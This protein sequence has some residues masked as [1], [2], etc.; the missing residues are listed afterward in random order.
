MRTALGAGPKHLMRQHGVEGLLYGLPEGVAGVAV[1]TA[2]IPAHALI[3]VDLPAWMQ[4]RLDHRNIAFAASAS[5]G[6]GLVISTASLASQM[7]PNLAK[8]LRQGDKGG[9]ET[10]LSSRSH[11]Q[12]IA[13][14]V[15]LSASLWGSR[16][17]STVKSAGG[18]ARAA[19][20]AVPRDTQWGLGG[21]L[22]RTAAHRGPRGSRPPRRNPP[23]APD[24]QGALPA[25]EYRRGVF[26]FSVQSE[27]GRTLLGSCFSHHFVTQG[28]NM[29][30]IGFGVCRRGRLARRSTAFPPI[31]SRDFST[32]AGSRTRE[33]TSL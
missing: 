28:R 15:P 13:A 7:R 32:S 9:L 19:A 26:G 29:I 33:V 23:A 11:W 18:A 12:L 17:W 2:T 4:F 21:D 6:A 10:S 1:A 31:P 16:L 3:P 27:V 30:L 25:A 8:V 22:P 14:Q 20:A 5:V 24:A